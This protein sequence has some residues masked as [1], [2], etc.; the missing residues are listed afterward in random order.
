MKDLKISQTKR[1]LDKF[2]DN[3]LSKKFLCLILATV[4]LARGLLSGQDWVI[5]AGI[6]LGSNVAQKFVTKN[7]GNGNIEGD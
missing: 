5:V 2:L 6:Y 4:L 1:R 7:N 3:L